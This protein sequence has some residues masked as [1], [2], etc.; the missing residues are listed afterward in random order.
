M[1][2]LEPPHRFCLY[3]GTFHTLATTNQGNIQHKGNKK[4]GRVGGLERVSERPAKI[5][6][7]SL[8]D[9]LSEAL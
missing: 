4:V 3:N 1:S 6:D 2:N 5:F 7:Q 9:V 8:H